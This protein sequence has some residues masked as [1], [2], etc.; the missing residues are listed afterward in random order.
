M[1]M[2]GVGG[3]HLAGLPHPAHHQPYPVSPEVLPDHQRLPV[4]LQ[5]LLQQLQRG[6]PGHLVPC[7]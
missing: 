5:I 6:S 7:G 2:G 1:G 4:R 3:N